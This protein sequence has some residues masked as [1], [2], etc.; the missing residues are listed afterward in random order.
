[1]CLM[2]RLHY[3][4]LNLSHL[5]SKNDQRVLDL[6]IQKEAG[7]NAQAASCSLIQN[8]R[9]LDRFRSISC[10]RHTLCSQLVSFVLGRSLAFLSEILSRHPK[11]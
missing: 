6:N 4:V 3:A 7:R 1:M 9:H 11:N 8:E 5:K 10:Y 2:Q